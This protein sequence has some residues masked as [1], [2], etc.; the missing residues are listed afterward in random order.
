MKRFAS[1]RVWQSGMVVIAAVL[2]CAAG[3]VGAVIDSFTADQVVMD[4]GG[5][6]KFQ[7]KIYMAPDRMRS[8]QPMGRQKKMV[9]I[10][11]RDKKELW[12]LDPAKKT[13]I[14]MPL[15]EEKWEQAAK[16]AVQSENAEVLGKETVNGYRCVKKQVTRQMEVM[17]MKMT[18]T[19]TIWVSDAFGIPIRTRSDD[20][21]VTELRNIKKGKPP[22]R[23]FEIPP[24]YKKVGN[25]MGALFMS[26]EGME[27]PSGG[28]PDSGQGKMKLPFK[29][30]KGMKLPFGGSN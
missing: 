8:D 25:D 1:K 12:A 15:D 10:Y 13:Y 17:G 19:Q 20:G 18:T 2:M 9:I 30:P 3:A 23:L 11:R 5:R 29:L 21:T 28:Q 16:G 4:A 24:G 7:G 22:A 27:M 6:V 26:M 14:Q